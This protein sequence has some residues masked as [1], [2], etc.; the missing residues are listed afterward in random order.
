MARQ[1]QFYLP[2]PTTGAQELHHFETEADQIADM[3]SFM[4]G[5]NKNGTDA[6]K[7]CT[8]LGANHGYRKAGTACALGDVTYINALTNNKKL[9]CVKAGTTGSE[10]LTVS[11]TAE[12]ALVTDGSVVW[13]IDSLA[14]GIYDAAHQNGSYRE[15]DLTA[16]WESGYM[17]INIQAGKF[18]GM[19]I[20][21]FIT[22]SVTTAATTYTDKA[23]TSVTQA[24]ATYSNVKWLLAGFDSHYLAGDTG[25][26][27]NSHAVVVIPD[28]A[29]QRNVSMNP[30][31]D[32]TGGYLGSD[33]WRV[34]MPIWATAIKNAFG[35]GHVLAH[36]EL[37]GNAI[38]AT[39]PSGAGTG[40]LGTTSS[41]AWTDVEVNIPNEQMIYG[42]R[43]F[44]SAEDGGDFPCHLPLFAHKQYVGGSDR[45][46]YWLRAVASA[47]SF[48]YASGNGLA[49]YLRASHS[50][51]NGGIRPYF[52]LR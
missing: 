35:S 6:E 41:W 29:L 28:K 10:S 26:G 19:H 34:H 49:N 12:G 39:A 46:W 37:L 45:S 13:E 7:V 1:S 8:L 48:A 40:W 17:S 33:M 9:V 27:V 36:R 18:V 42:G 15:A 30:T 43:V 52:L 38:N 23:G 11:N 24:A 47:S 51:A 16:Y 2:N 50:Y 22:K 25:S 21:D 3:Q 14:D 4:R 5:V 44:G 20:G 31:D 32:T